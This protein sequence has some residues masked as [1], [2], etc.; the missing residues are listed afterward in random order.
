MLWMW[1][2]FVIGCGP[3]KP[4]ENAAADLTP[5]LPS[6]DASLYTTGS[7]TPKDP[8]VARL[9]AQSGIA[10]QES[11][12][13]AATYLTLHE[14][15]APELSLAR[16]GAVRA[17]YPHPIHSITFGTFPA[18]TFPAV[19]LS[20]LEAN[21]QPGDELGLVR[22]RTEFGDRW[23][24]LIG[25]PV[26]PVVSLNRE[27]P[28]GERVELSGN[29][30]WQ[31]QSPDGDMLTGALPLDQALLV[32]GEWWLALRTRPGA[33]AAVS[34]PLYVGMETPPAPIIS[35]PGEESVRPTESLDILYDLV[36]QLRRS[37]DLN[38]LR[39]D[40]TLETLAQYPLEQGLAGA[41]EDSTGT[42]RLRAAGFVGGPAGQVYCEGRTVALCLDTLMWDIKSREALLSPGM[43]LMGAAAEVRTDQIALLL[44]V[45]S[46]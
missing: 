32:P 44:N 27:Y 22:S 12:S 31:L 6:P 3:R 2:F 35:L 5:I 33:P 9:V 10:W 30:H 39:V 17:G 8:L 21:M 1:P 43:R 36:D 16:W 29:G 28:L 4:T 18:D 23:I 37:F 13:G 11:L 34:I 46:E 41:R 25:H 19:L 42:A 20:E 14:P 38:P 15:F 45:A 24:A 7:S 40:V 26:M